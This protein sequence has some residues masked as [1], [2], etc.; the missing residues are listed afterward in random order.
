MASPSVKLKVVRKRNPFHP[1]DPDK[2]YVQAVKSAKVNLDWLARYV[3]SRSTVSKA[4][5]YA[6]LTA[7]VDA[8]LEELSRGSIVSLGS[9]GNFQVSIN[10]SGSD[11]IEQVSVENVKS[12]HLNFRPSVEVKEALKNLKYTLSDSD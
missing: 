6:V 12:A 1:N 9:L 10:S 11:S 4:D 3:S 7:C 2:Y 8:M 5:C